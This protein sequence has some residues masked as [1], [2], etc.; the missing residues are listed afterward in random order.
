MRDRRHQ[1]S[2]LPDRTAPR[3]TIR[4]R[5]RRRSGTGKT[6]DQ[7]ARRNQPAR[8]DTRP[9][10]RR[11]TTAARRGPRSARRRSNGPRRRTPPQPSRNVPRAQS[12]PPRAARPGRDAERNAHR[13]RRARYHSPPR[14]TRPYSPPRSSY[15]PFP[16]ILHSIR[17]LRDLL[18]RRDS[19]ARAIIGATVFGT[20]DSFGGGTRRKPPRPL[21]VQ[22]M[23]RPQGQRP[24]TLY[25]HRRTHG[26]GAKTAQ[27]TRQHDD[28]RAP[29][30][31]PPP[32]SIFRTVKHS[33]GN[34]PASE[35][36]RAAA[37]S[38]SLDVIDRNGRGPV[39]RL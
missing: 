24:R 38:L 17:A 39:S 34:S 2:S 12:G 27:R 1:R 11:R 32:S 15:A 31:F 13:P 35:R 10:P 29:A 3:A 7:P 37:A 28:E 18:H 5:P 36:H 9:T 21:D 20:C 4:A 19:P 25:K 6:S 22:H 14:E 33:N 8:Q 30:H 16:D 26:C 23:R